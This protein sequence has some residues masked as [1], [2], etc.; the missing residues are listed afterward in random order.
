MKQ[1]LKWIEIKI[2]ALLQ[3]FHRSAERHVSSKFIY[4]FKIKILKYTGL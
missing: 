4:G 3:L 2:Y 1:M